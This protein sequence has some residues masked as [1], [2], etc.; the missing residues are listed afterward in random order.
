[1]LT[2]YLSPNPFPLILLSRP[3]LAILIAFTSPSSLIRYH[4]VLLLL[5]YNI[6][7]FPHYSLYIERSAWISFL[8]PEASTQC[9]DSFEKLLL[10]GWDAR[11]RGPTADVRLRRKLAKRSSSQRFGDAK[12]DESCISV[13]SASKWQRLKFGIWVAFSQR[14][15]GSPWQARNVPAYDSSRPSYVPTR[16][17]YCLTKLRSILISYLLLDIMSQASRPDQN[18]ILFADDKIPLLSRWNEVTLE[19]IIV[20]FSAS[21][22]FWIGVF[23]FVHLYYS[24]LSLIS[25]LSGIDKPE[26]RGPL[27]GSVKDAYT[28]RRFWSLFWHQITRKR[29]TKPA[30]FITFRILQLPRSADAPYQSLR[31]LSRYTEH[32]FVFLISGLIHF[33]IDAAA[34]IPWTESGALHCFLLM[35]LGIIM[36]DAA[37]WLVFDIVLGSQARGSGWAKAVG[38][39]WVLLWLVIATPFYPYPSLQRVTGGP[40]DELL[41]Y[42]V[43][44]MVQ[45]VKW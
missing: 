31:L 29:L 12:L 40:K 35:A 6:H 45:K 16:Q 15:I 39:L 14:Y 24:T 1:M 43:V 22:G 25:V 36:E 3:L 19:E 41:P 4:V 30:R 17:R 21:I 18:P 26:N 7:V 28:L 23:L 44:A 20:R 42:S 34:G 33:A 27:F 32:F 8:A 37:Q 5:A 2:T 10:T 38:Y 9:M 11:F 13:E